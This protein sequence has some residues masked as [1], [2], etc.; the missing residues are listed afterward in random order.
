[1]AHIWGNL[2]VKGI[3]ILSV[4]ITHGMEFDNEKI[5]KAPYPP[6]PDPN[7]EPPPDPEP[8]PGSDPDLIPG[9]DPYPEPMPM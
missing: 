6:L 7:P 9:T 2:Q 4:G 1:L 3:A 8:Q 5:S